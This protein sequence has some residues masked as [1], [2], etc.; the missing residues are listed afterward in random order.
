MTR[1]HAKAPLSIRVGL[2]RASAFALGRVE[3]ARDT[4]HDGGDPQAPAT[5]VHDGGDPQAPAT[6]VHDGG[7]PQPPTQ[8]SGPTG[9]L[10]L[11]VS[12]GSF[13]DVGDILMTLNRPAVTAGLVRP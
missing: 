9:E 12:R 7:D 1:R 8:P 3:A 10:V 4:G 6:G 11:G 2:A 13:E 5:G